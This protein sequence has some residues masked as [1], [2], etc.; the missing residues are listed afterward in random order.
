VTR[1]E[2][3]AELKAIKERQ[4]DLETNR[5]DAEDVLLKLINDDAIMEAFKAIDTWYA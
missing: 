1:D 2:A 4:S 3:L 5:I